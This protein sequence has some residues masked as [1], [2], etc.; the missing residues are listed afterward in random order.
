MSAQTETK[1]MEFSPGLEGVIAA[2]STISYI[3]GQAGRLIY[4][5]IPIEALTEESS[6]EEVSYLL[7]R[8]RLPTS[9]EL[10]GFDRE[11]KASRAVPETV[12]RI[13]GDL[14]AA[15]PMA[16]L[17]TA[18]S[19][20]GLFDPEAEAPSSEA[21]M[22]KAIRLIAQFATIIAAIYR[23]RG[24]QKP[25]APRQD[26]SHAANFL[27]MLNGAEPDATTARVI[28]VGLILHADHGFNASTFTARV[29]YS[30]ESDMYSA[31]TAA[32]G[33]LKGPLHGGANEQALR[34]LREIGTPDGAEA[35]YKQ[36]RAERRRVP[37]FGHRVYKAYDPRARIL[38]RFA[39]ELA[40]VQGEVDSFELSAKL[41][42]LVI[43]DLGLTRGIFPN[44]DFYSAS[45]YHFLGIE[46]ELFTP[47]F[48]MSRISG[49][50]AHVLEQQAEN[51]LFRPRSLYEGSMDA[52]YVPIDQ[53]G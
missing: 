35:W 24:G 32:I 10:D 43:N 17:R 48:A 14:P 16:V 3:D 7:L 25:I 38:K 29:V 8:G 13:I 6:F 22:R 40:E 31:I 4:R 23:V 28:D 46:P 5:G 52:P 15:S 19:A 49:W 12:L 30:T 20:V 33:S 45:V 50:A 27:Y 21:N 44:V 2:R 42:D 1:E 53:R 9:A 47:I 11:L 51:R 41:E 37:G 39:Q 26:L 36:A 34:M 18:V